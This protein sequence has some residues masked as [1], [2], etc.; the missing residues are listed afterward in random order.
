MD[1]ARECAFCQ[2]VAGATEADLVL[3]SD[4]FVAFLD[5]R[6]VF[7]GHVLLVPPPARRRPTQ[8]RRP[9]VAS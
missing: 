1:S 3:E 2:I 6:P 7:K 9:G 8:T 4:D 5:R